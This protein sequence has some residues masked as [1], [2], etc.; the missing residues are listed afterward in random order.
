MGTGTG[1]KFYPWVQPW[2]DMDN[3]RGMIAGGYLLYPI[4]TRPIAIPN[5]GNYQN[6]P[7]NLAP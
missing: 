6:S 3:P 5:R 1:T 7:K 4:R 2:A